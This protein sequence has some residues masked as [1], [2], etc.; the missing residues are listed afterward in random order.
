MTQKVVTGAQ[1]GQKLLQYLSRTMP[2]AP[3][4]FFYRMLRA[5]NIT[6]N[7]KKADGKEILAEGDVISFFLAEETMEKFGAA[8]ETASDASVKASRKEETSRDHE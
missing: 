5:K 4:S 2:G 7:K 3:M 8:G 1:S 6:L